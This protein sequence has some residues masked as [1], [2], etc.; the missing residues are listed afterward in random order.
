[1]VKFENPEAA[2]AAVK[3]YH[4]REFCRSMSIVELDRMARHEGWS[5]EKLV[6]WRSVW[7]SW[8]SVVDK[9]F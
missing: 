8:T 4:S 1:M 3:R 6:Y 9:P 7:S 5:P 2:R